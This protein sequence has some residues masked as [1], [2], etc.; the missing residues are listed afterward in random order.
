MVTLGNGVLERSRSICWG[1]VLRL[2]ETQVHAD[3]LLVPLGSTD[4]ILG[5]SRLQ[6]LGLMM[7]NWKRLTMTFIPDGR[8]VTLIGERKISYFI[9]YLLILLFIVS[10]FI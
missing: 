9:I 4:V 2:P 1:L 5:T 10:S 6:T 7:F 8:Q 3:F